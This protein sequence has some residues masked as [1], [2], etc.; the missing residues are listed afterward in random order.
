LFLNIVCPDNY[1]RRV[2]L[3]KL[4]EKLLHGQLNNSLLKNLCPQRRVKSRLA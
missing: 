1:H 3:Q 4:L 2:K